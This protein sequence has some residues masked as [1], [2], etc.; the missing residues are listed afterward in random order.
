ML[1]NHH[2]GGAAQR[3]TLSRAQLAH[4]TKP[5][6]HVTNLVIPYVRDL[7]SSLLV[8]AS[9]RAGLLAI[10]RKEARASPPRLRPL[11]APAHARTSYTI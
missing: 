8:F 7:E 5:V 9:R 3:Q 2:F 11:L 10:S 1:L 4:V 6:S